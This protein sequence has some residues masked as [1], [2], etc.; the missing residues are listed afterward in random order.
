MLLSLPKSSQPKSQFS[1]ASSAGATRVIN[2]A[3]VLVVWAAGL[4]LPGGPGESG[5]AHR[6]T[7]RLP[8]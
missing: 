6:L 1:E 2:A 5:A 3:L 7:E 4:L 8:E